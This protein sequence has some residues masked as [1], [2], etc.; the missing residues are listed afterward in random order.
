MKDAAGEAQKAA[1]DKARE[2][3]TAENMMKGMTMVNE[4]QSKY[5]PKEDK[6]ETAAQWNGYSNK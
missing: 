4:A 5:M 6:Q 1:M 3:G 2:A